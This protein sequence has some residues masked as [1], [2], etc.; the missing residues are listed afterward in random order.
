M[1]SVM[2]SLNQNMKQTVKLVTLSIGLHL[3]VLNHLY[4][5]IKYI[6]LSRVILMVFN[7]KLQ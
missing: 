6:V 1:L 5:M 4:S 2:L 7:Y 3:C